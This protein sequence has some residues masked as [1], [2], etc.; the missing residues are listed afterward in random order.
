MIP[1]RFL[2]ASEGGPADAV[3]R[4]QSDG[5]AYPDAFGVRER[6]LERVGVVPPPRY[7]PRHVLRMAQSEAE[8][9]SGLVQG[10]IACAVAMLADN[11]RGD[12]GEGDRGTA[13]LPLSGTA[14]ASGS[15]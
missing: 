12:C 14:Q 7:L 10:P 13:A 8:R 1:D 4:D 15:A 9:R 2:K 6:E 11:R 5:R 3:Q